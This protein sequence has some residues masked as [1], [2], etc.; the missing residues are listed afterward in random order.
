MAV[1]KIARGGGH[2]Q[3]VAAILPALFCVAAL[4]SPAEASSF[5]VNPVQIVMATDNQSTTLTLTNSD[6]APVS[7]R[8]LAYVWSQERGED[9]YTPTSGLI[10]SPPIFTVPAGKTQLV[11]IGFKSKPTGGAY[12]I[13]FE[14]IT[15][16]KPADGRVQ[17]SLRLN[18]PLYVVP[19]VNGKAQV[20]WSA[21]RDSAGDVVVQGRNAG[22]RHSQILQ[23][24]SGTG[25]TR[26][27]LS[28]QM[29]VVL[30]GSARHWK[31]GKRPELAAGAPFTL[32][33]KG[34]TGETQTQIVL[35]QR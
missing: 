24:E 17:V 30:P 15:L 16:E 34:A 25:N 21:W 12:R 32:T 26:Q 8:V 1:G 35:E 4:A 22:T 14:E 33:V 7:L 5:R 13:I 28:K 18:L 19:K 27:T 3:R 2:S 31:A 20:N 29:G 11:R 23:L 6:R 10:A 9:V